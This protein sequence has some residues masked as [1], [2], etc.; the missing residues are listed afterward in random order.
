MGEFHSTEK[1]WYKSNSATIIYFY[2]LIYLRLA[3][4]NDHT[5]FVIRCPQCGI[6]FM[7]KNSN[8]ARDDILC[9]FGCRQNNKK[10]NARKRSKDRNLRNKEKKKKLNRARSENTTTSTI[11]SPPVKVDPF[12][13]YLQL[14][15]TSILKTKIQIDEIIELQEKVR[16]RGLSFYQ[17]LVH[18]SDYG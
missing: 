2:Y 8:Y 16:S 1:N 4:K 5:S 3:D 6:L 13:L 18:H 9:P 14:T 15:L 12:A 17:R 7:T 10:V 11:L